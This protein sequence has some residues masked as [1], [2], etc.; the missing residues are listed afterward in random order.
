MIWAHKRIKT[1]PIKTTNRDLVGVIIET[2]NRVILVIA[3]YMPP[4]SN[5]GD[6]ELYLKLDQIRS[7]ITETRRNHIRQLELVIGG[8]FNRYDQLWGGD[9]VALHDRQGEGEPVI[10][11]MA[12]LDL[13]SLLPR[14]TPIWYSDTAELQSTIDLMMAIL[15]LA[16]EL[17]WCTTGETEH[18]SDHQNIRTA[19]YIGIT[20]TTT[21]ARRLWKKADWAQIIRVL[22]Q[23]LEVYP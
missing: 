2:N 9:E 1:K 15:E 12:D 5:R 7:L 3:A 10:E 14:G 19:F 11:L 18:G 21:A 13:Q 8:D 6:E 16:N 17:A 23:T 22:E 4:K 20:I